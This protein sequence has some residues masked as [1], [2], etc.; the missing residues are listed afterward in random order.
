MTI[1]VVHVHHYRSGPRWTLIVA[2]API[3]RLRASLLPYIERE[4]HDHI[5]FG[6]V[7]AAPTASKVSA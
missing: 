4:A 1:F 7:V 5:G 6:V 2:R 3:E